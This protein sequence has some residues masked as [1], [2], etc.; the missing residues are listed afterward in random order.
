MTY[1]VELDDQ[2][3]T[4]FS[5]LADAEA[6]AEEYRDTGDYRKVSVRELVTDAPL[7]EESK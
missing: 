6:F 2:H 4:G 5:A 1:S 7:T 3:I